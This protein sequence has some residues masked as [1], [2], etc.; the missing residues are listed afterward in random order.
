M[1]NIINL[2]MQVEQCSDV[3]RDFAEVDA[4]VNSSF[5]LVSSLLHKTLG[6]AAEFYK[7]SLLY[8]AFTPIETLSVTQR[9]A[10]AYDLG[11]AALC[12]EKQYQFGELLL[13]PILQSLQ[14]TAAQW[15]VDML[16]A[17]NAGDIHAFETVS[18][19]HGA[20]IQAEQALVANSQRLREKIRIFALMQLVREMPAHSRTLPFADIATRTS[21]PEEE[22]ELLLMRSLSLSLIKGSINQVEAS[23]RV[24]WVQ[25]RVMDREAIGKQTSKLKDWMEKVQRTSVFLANETPE[26]LA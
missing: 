14:G 26:I 20:A 11:L 21:L 5:Y 7:N 10:L 8:L 22:V 13:H 23:V 19:V 16:H 12:G 24:T 17:F 4:S 3:V 18:K 6:D 1:A 2:M 25:P 15:L 9:Q